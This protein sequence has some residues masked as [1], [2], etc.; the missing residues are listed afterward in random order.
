MLAGRH[1]R[2]LIAAVLAALAASGCGESTTRRND[3]RP[4][5]PITITASVSRD[6]VSVSPARFGA[7][8][9]RLIVVNQ[10][11]AAQQVT[12]ESALAPGEGPGVRQQ[13]APINPQDTATL[14]ADV[15]PGRY[16]VRVSGDAIKR[17]TLRVGRDRPSAQ[18]DLLQ[19]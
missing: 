5:A 10:T 2:V 18:N 13:T 1:G 11:S 7:G 8:P 15:R 16:M 9:V 4:A 14:A 6:R 3:A 19:P 12:L 17:A